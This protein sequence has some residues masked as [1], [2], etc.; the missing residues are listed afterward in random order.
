MYVC[1]TLYVCI[2]V[3]MYVCAHVYPTICE[4]VSV[5]VC[6]GAEKNSVSVLNFEEVEVVGELT[7][8]VSEDESEGCRDR[9]TGR[10]KTDR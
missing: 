6:V 2:Y 1:M 7:A 8:G 4:Y 5:V 10:K 3:Y 9:R